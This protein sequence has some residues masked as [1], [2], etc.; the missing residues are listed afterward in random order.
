[1]D[2]VLAAY[3]FYVRSSR[4]AGCG[5]IEH[6]EGHEKIQKIWE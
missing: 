4:P 2:T 3:W 1:M 5:L 6:L